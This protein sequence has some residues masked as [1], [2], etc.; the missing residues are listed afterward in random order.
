M[1]LREGGKLPVISHGLLQNGPAL[2]DT[3][4]TLFQLTWQTANLN[5]TSLL[6]W[7]IIMVAYDLFSRSF[8]SELKRV[9]P[10]DFLSTVMDT[11]G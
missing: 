7:S 4:P 10:P 2:T 8:P 1:K 5:K 6:L 9:I 11:K 3:E